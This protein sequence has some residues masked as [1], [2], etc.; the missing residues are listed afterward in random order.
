MENPDHLVYAD[1]PGFSLSAAGIAQAR[2]VARY[3]G[4]RPVVAVWS[5]PLER[6]L[7]TAESIASRH[8]LPVRVDEA[9]AEWA[10]MARWAGRSWDAL[11]DEFPGELAALLDQPHDLAF[12]PETLATLS[13]RV[14]AAVK[15][16]SDQA[17]LGE[18]VIVS[19]SAAVRSATLALVGDP[20]SGFGRRDPAHGSVT[21]LRPGQPWRVEVTW[22]PEV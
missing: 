1:L 16:R 14:A 20:L 2:A 11:D 5:S 22:E 9:L 13:E 18:I 4:R 6:A 21:T 17:A 12:S 10:L 8:G 15:A 19:H 7:R 3:L